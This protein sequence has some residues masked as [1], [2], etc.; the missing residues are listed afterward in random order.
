MGNIGESLDFLQ[1]SNLSVVLKMLSSSWNTFGDEILP[2]R[3]HRRFVLICNL[4]ND[5]STGNSTWH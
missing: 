2:D 5:V 1:D 4:F 3:S